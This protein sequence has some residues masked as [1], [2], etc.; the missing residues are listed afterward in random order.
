ME[1]LHPE[2]KEA[3]KR[4]HPDLT[5]E[6]IDRVEELNTLRFE[7]D[8]EKDIDKIR[9]IDLERSELLQRKMARY[10][11]IAQAFA[12]SGARPKQR[13]TPKVEIKRHDD[14]VT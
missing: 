5:D 14:G 3:L 2:L 11:E 1:P 4:A 9:E 10:K 12:A 7:L 8:P 13:R 6:D